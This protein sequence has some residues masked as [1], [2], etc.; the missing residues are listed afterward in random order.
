MNRILCDDL[1]RIFH[2]IF[3]FM[4]FL[5]CENCRLIDQV[6]VDNRIDWCVRDE[7]ND[8]KITFWF[9]W[10][11]HVLVVWK[12]FKRWFFEIHCVFCDR[13]VFECFINLLY[14]DVHAIDKNVREMKN[15]LMKSEIHFIREST[16]CDKM[17][18]VNIVVKM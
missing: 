5:Y 14:D 13:E 18:N 16:K 6:R 4:R 1:Q 8:H 10:S 12:V 11:R 7:S 2:D 3:F 15:H 17:M 9:R